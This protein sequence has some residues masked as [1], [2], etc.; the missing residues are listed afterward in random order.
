M[1]VT[2]RSVGPGVVVKVGSG[3]LVGVTGVG[4]GGT[5]VLVGVAE[6]VGV[7]VGVGWIRLMVA[8][9]KKPVP[10]VAITE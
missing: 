10:L 6:A 7:L 3:V 8:R 2:G 5:V 4:V 9:V 1:G